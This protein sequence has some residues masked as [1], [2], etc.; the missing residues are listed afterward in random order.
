[1][2]MYNEL[3]NATMTYTECRELVKPD[4][5]FLGIGTIIV[6]LIFFG[7]VIYL[8]I[9]NKKMSTFIKDSKLEEHFQHHKNKNKG[10]N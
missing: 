1:M 5:L 9:Q 7:F 6:C 10:L 8:T 3:L 2:V 4:I